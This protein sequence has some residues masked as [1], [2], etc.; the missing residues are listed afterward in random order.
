MPD[1]VRRITVSLPVEVYEALEARAKAEGRRA[2]NL[3][4]FLLTTKI[5]EETDTKRLTQPSTTEKE[6]PASGTSGGKGKGKGEK[7]KR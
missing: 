3:A 2:S 1:Q 5:Q 6:P 7:N 4:A